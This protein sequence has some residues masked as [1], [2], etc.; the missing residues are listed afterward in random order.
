MEISSELP[1]NEMTVRCAHKYM[2]ARQA[3]E[4]WAVNVRRVQEYC[5]QGRVKGAEHVGNMWLIPEDAK[6]PER[7]RK[8][9]KGTSERQEAE[10]VSKK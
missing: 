8:K 6:K 2:T 4:K 1:G 7:L 9:G 5:A 3:A 10:K